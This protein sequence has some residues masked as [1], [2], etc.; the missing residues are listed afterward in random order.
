MSKLTRF[1]SAQWALA[2]LALYYGSAFF[3]AGMSGLQ[4]M[5][6]QDYGDLAVSFEIEAM[7][8]VQLSAALMLSFGLLFNGRW[9]WSAAMRLAGAVALA[10]LCAMLSASALEAAN[11]WPVAIYC[12]GFAGFGVLVAWWNL[13]DL[14]AAIFWWPDGQIP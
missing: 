11:G 3:I 13:V 6:P 9:R 8:G 4:A 2:I 14:R 5:A 7:A 12:S 1:R 10:A